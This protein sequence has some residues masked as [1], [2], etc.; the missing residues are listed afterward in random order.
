MDQRNQQELTFYAF[1]P[2]QGKGRPLGKIDVQPKPSEY[3]WALSSNASR[4]AVV[5]DSWQ[6]DRIRV[7]SLADGALQTVAVKGWTRIQ[8]IS[9]AP[10]GEGWIVSCVSEKDVLKGAMLLHVDPNGNVHV[11]RPADWGVVSPDGQKLAYPGST[12]VANAWMIE[13]F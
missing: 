4:V 10:D 12:T 11:L 5:V 9:W 1:D 8:S 7:L 13:N 3:G 6:E 2:V